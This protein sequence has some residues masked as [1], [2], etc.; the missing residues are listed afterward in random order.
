MSVENA[1]AELRRKKQH[2]ERA[3]R[4]LELLQ[5]LEQ[6]GEAGGLNDG[7]E[8]SSASNLIEMPRSLRG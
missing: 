2:V 7:I 1:L 5:Q 8:R 4:A 6:T 3:I